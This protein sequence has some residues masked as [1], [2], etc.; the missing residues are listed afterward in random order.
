M[1]TEY[2]KLNARHKDA[3]EYAREL[4]RLLANQGKRSRCRQCVLW[5]VLAIV[6]FLTLFL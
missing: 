6:G 2:T 4:E 1:T 3:T 5:V